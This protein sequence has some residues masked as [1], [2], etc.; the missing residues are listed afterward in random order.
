MAIKEQLKRVRCMIEAKDIE[1]QELAILAFHSL[2]T[3][4]QG[5]TFNECSSFLYRK[6]CTRARINIC[7]NR[8][9]VGTF[10][11][12]LYDNYENRRDK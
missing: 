11:Y 6:E 9:K 8:L 2:P 1:M 3:K 7:E 5:D 4:W 12:S 10:Y